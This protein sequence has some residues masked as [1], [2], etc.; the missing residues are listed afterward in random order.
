MYLCIDIGGTAIKYGILEDL[1]QDVRL[2]FKQEVPSNAKADRGPGIAK[3]VVELAHEM[4]ARYNLEGIAI[5]TAGMVDP[6]TG[7]ILYANENIPEYTG[8]NL[9]DTL[10]RIF[11]LPCVIEND[12][13]AA[14]LGEYAYGA[15]RGCK[16]LLCLTVGTGIGGALILNDTIYYGHSGSAGEIGYMLINGEAFQGIASTSALV[17]RVRERY[18]LSAAI[19][20]KQIFAQAKQ[21]DRICQEEI[22]KTCDILAQGIA[23]CLCLMNPEMVVLG[24]GI[25][26]QQEYLR[27]IIENSLKKYAN[28]YILRHTKLAFANLGNDAGMIGAYA[29]LKRN[30]VCHS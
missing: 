15:G 12:V 14:A 21:N 5:S 29:K 3:K 2:I 16:S 19:D 1:R 9:K 23:N 7:E 13:N 24:G 20:G 18:G 30:L 4:R 17:S 27:T 11:A 28:P 8:M 10:T 25:M 6:A 22:E 26:V